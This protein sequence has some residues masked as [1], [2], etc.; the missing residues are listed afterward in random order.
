M[1]LAFWVFVLF[2]AAGYVACGWRSTFAPYWYLAGGWRWHRKLRR[3]T[4]ECY[5][6]RWQLL[7]TS[8]VCI[9]VNR[10]NTPDYDDLPH[11]HPWPRAYSLKLRRS[12]IE[13]VYTY[14]PGEGDI[15]IAVG[16]PSRLNRIPA[17]HRIVKVDTGG[18]WTLF[19]G[20]RRRPGSDKAWGFV[21][22]DGKVIPADQRKAQRG[23]TSES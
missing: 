19:V 23:V 14:G 6:D 13:E 2:M 17:V 15:N 4:G 22:R 1:T 16:R 10:I 18:A 5:M 9:Y 21:G 20:F 8:L 7:K 12:Y 3:E 11:T